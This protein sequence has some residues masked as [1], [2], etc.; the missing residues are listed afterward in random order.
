MN[1]IQDNTPRILFLA[2]LIIVAV[3]SRLLPHPP[4][5]TAIAA[6]ALFAGAHFQSRLLAFAVPLVTMFATDQILGLHSTLLPVYAAFALTVCIGLII[7]GKQKPH[8]IA[9]GAV[10]ASLLFFLITNFAVWMSGFMYPMNFQGLMM[11]YTAALPFFQN[12]LAGDLFYSGILFGIYYLASQ[13]Y[14]Q[15][16]TVKK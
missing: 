6:V 11:C 14:P 12:T 16:I 4:N 5:F 10:S 1:S 2:L 15:L 9:I 8:F 3:F 13:K 7:S